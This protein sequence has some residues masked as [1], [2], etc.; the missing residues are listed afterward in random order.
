M[1]NPT[2]SFWA[3]PC[4]DFVKFPMDLFQKLPKRHKKPKDTED[5]SPMPTVSAVPSLIQASTRI[6]ALH[7]VKGDINTREDELASTAA[8]PKTQSA[9]DQQQQAARGSMRGG[10]SKT[11]R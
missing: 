9:A 11:D 3:Q 1:V 10:G 4:P 5:S 6:A 7:A 2:H 8:A